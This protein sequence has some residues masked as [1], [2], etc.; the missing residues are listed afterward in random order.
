L[1][2]LLLQV[3]FLAQV[4]RERGQFSIR[5]V[6][7]TIRDKIVRRHPH[8]FGSQRME[9]AE[10]VLHQWERIKS[11]ER[12]AA[13]TFLLQGTPVSLPAL[14]KAWRLAAKAARVGFDWKSAAGALE[15]VEE[16]L[17]ELRE[18]ASGA[19]GAEP[20]RHEIGD[21]LFAVANLARHLRVDAESAL[22]EANRRFTE[23]FTHME[24]A[25]R[26]AGRQFEELGPA[27]LDALWEAAKGAA[28]IPGAP[29]DPPAEG[30]K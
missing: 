25:L 16:E 26:R 8:V 4:A 2:D 24:Q 19:G 14:L 22:Q 17:G 9:T 7:E 10:E 28:G 30:Q 15:K 13:G 18:A 12:Q 21:L 20:I 11:R 5:E 23:R 27:E 29:G 3:V 1:G 6:V